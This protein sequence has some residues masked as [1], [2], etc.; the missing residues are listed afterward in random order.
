MK[1]KNIKINCALTT[2]LNLKINKYSKVALIIRSYLFFRSWERTIF[3][4]I[5]ASIFS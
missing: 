4:N 1:I 3:K 5:L 2:V